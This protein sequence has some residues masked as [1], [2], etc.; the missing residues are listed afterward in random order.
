MRMCIAQMVLLEKRTGE[1]AF[2]TLLKQYSF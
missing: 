1:G 2:I